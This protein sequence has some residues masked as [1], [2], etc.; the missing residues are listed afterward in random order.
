MVGE[1]MMPAAIIR[2]D[3]FRLERDRRRARDRADGSG[4][5]ASPFRNRLADVILSARQ[6]A[7]R[8]AMLDFGDQHRRAAPAP[9]TGAATERE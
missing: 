4:V 7:H 8:R 9:F 6:I 3:S 1:G 5:A 2:F